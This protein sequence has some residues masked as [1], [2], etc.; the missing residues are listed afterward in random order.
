[1]VAY[2]GDEKS[3]GYQFLY[4]ADLFRIVATGNMALLNSTR[5]YI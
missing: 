5:Y 1:M 4:T 3:L 2:N